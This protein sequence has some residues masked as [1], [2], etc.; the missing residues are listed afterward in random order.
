M[1]LIIEWPDLSGKTTLIKKLKSIFGTSVSFKL[2]YEVLPL[3]WSEF[4]RK[5]IFYWY[6]TWVEFFK[7]YLEQFPNN[8]IIQDRF[9]VSELVYWKIF[10]WYEPFE[11]KNLPKIE[12]EL[13]QIPHLLI[14][15][16]DDLEWYKK[17]FEK[18]WD[19]K[20]KKF[21]TF[22]KLLNRYNEVIDKVNLNK[23]IVEPFKD[24]E[25]INK[26]INKII[27]LKNISKINNENRDRIA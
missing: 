1:L 2:P 19:D 22:K 6:L 7:R 27:E 17:R 9:Y 15:L 26:I 4:E 3:D 25:H 24:E 18:H 8:Y 14:Y 20:I 12:E 23:I 16:K 11:D 21:D 13:K 10:R 5:K